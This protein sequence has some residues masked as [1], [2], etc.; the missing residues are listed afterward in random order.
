MFICELYYMGYKTSE[1]TPEDLFSQFLAKEAIVRMCEESQ[2]K[3]PSV[4]ERL[5]ECLAAKEGAE[6]LKMFQA[7][8]LK[9]EGD[10]NNYQRRLVSD[11]LLNSQQK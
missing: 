3:F 2:L 10:W 11:P 5:D 9:F 7:V 4:L 1:I 6:A 8:P